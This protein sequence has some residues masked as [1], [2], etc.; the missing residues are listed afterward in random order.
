MPKKHSLSNKSPHGEIPVE[1]DSFSETKTLL[2]E[3]IS[4]KVATQQIPI[5]T[6]IENMSL[7]DAAEV[8]LKVYGM[9]YRRRNHTSTSNADVKV[10]VV[11]CYLQN[12]TIQQIVE[13]LEVNKKKS[14][15]KSAIGRLCT[16]LFRSGIAPIG[17]AHAYGFKLQGGTGEI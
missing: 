5:Q 17:S 10:D 15:S 13:W 6:I 8:A 3:R 14:M 12:M 16:R 9:S 4:R 1:T 7:D 2:S 11:K